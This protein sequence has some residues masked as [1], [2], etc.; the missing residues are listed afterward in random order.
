MKSENLMKLSVF[1]FTFKKDIPG[2]IFKNKNP[3][4]MYR[5]LKK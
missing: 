2:Q 4:T 3:V 5:V 1:S